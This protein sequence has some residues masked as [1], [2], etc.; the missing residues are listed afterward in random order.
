MPDIGPSFKKKGK[1]KGQKKPLSSKQ[2]NRE[3][4]VNITDAVFTNR[5]K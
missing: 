2:K 4:D 5:R 3:S 1:G